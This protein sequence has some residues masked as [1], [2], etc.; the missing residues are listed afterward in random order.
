VV[1][2]PGESTRIQDL[3]I[4]EISH[5]TFKSFARKLK[6]KIAAGI[7]KMQLVKELANYKVLEPQRD[8]MKGDVINSSILGT[9]NSLPSG[10]LHCSDGTIIPVILTILDPDNRECYMV[11]GQQISHGELRANEKY[12]PNYSRPV[13]AYNN[14]DN[15]D[16]KMPVSAYPPIK[17]SA[18]SMVFMMILLC[19]LMFLMQLSLHRCSNSFTRNTG[20]SVIELIMFCLSHDF[21]GKE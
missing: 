16:Y 21:F 7:T 12:I 5:E 15:D 14:A 13:V 8:A 11:T 18:T 3:P 17:I 1:D 9:G 4:S 2:K 19:N 20:T 10:L 6:L